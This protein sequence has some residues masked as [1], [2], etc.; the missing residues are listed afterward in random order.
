M[1]AVLNQFL[2]Q[3]LLGGIV[4]LLVIRELRAFISS[5]KD[6]NPYNDYHWLIE[7]L[8]SIVDGVSGVKAEIAE[9]NGY[10]KGLLDR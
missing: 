2:G 5:K 3:S 8:D 9:L 4:L 10:L 7:K 6:L 1:E